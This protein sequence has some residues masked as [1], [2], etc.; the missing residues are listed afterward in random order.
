MQYGYLSYLNP[1]NAMYTYIMVDYTE[2][3]YWNEDYTVF[4]RD[5][6]IPEYV[7][8]EIERNKV[9]YLT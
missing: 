9:I 8:L 5:M 2:T 6:N 4:E 3:E 7:I 1:Y